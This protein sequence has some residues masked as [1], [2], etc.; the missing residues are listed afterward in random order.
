M[1]CAS[2]KPDMAELHLTGILN[3][4]PFRWVERATEYNDISAIAAE[5][6]ERTYDTVLN[7]SSNVYANSVIYSLHATSPPHI[8]MHNVDIIICR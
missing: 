3:V 6:D 7:V 8:R 5:H 2:S 1:R 4:K